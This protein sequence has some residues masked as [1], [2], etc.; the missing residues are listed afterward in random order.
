MKFLADS[1][2]G[3]LLGVWRFSVALGGGSVAKPK[4]AV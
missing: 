2:L 4:P 3:E 1:K